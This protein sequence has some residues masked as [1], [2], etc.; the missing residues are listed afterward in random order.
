MDFIQAS[1]DESPVSS[2]AAGHS[3]AD[4]RALPTDAE[5]QSHISRTE[6][7]VYLQTAE[8]DD[9]GMRYKQVDIISSCKTVY[10][11]FLIEIQRIRRDLFYNR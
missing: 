4:N 9:K 6:L 11:F 2:E 3:L 7:L 8:K 1:Q 10:F 5:G